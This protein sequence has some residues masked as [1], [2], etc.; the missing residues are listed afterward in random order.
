MSWQRY[1]AVLILGWAVLGATLG[2]LLAMP[3]RLLAVVC[4]VLALPVFVAT[5]FGTGRLF[6]RWNTQD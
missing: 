1:T 4:I 5:G 2:L 6:S 3:T